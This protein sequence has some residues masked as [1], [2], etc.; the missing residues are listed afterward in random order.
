MEPVSRAGFILRTA[1]HALLDKAAW[2]NHLASRVTCGSLN[3]DRLAYGIA[4]D[5][6]RLWEATLHNAPT[7][8]D[9]DEVLVAFCRSALFAETHQQFKEG[10]A[11]LVRDL[12]ASRDYQPWLQSLAASLT[13]LILPEV[14]D[15]PMER[16]LTTLSRQENGEA[17]LRTGLRNS[18]AGVTGGQL[19]HGAAD[20]SA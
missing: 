16:V 4:A 6:L 3:C 18:L 19:A 8:Q 13:E 11:N 17:I 20:I 5:M 12:L 9:Y 15:H 1:T 14:A 2:L 7:F 10:A